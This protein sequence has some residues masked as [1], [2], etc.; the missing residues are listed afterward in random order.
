LLRLGFGSK[1]TSSALCEDA[2]GVSFAFHLVGRGWTECTIAIDERHTIIIASYLSDALGDLLDTVIR[3]VEGQPE[4]TVSIADEPGAYRWRFFRREPDRLLIRILEFPEM[5]GD[6]PDDEGQ[7]LF[8]AECRLRT[9][10]GA[11]LSE[12]QRL[13]EKLGREGYLGIWVQHEFPLAKQERLR[14]LLGQDTR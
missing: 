3:V 7:L 5:W 6:R 13:L 2:M 12:S 9:F 8:D 11:V 14:Q 1:I 4:A 10:A